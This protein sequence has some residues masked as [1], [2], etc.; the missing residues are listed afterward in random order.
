[1]NPI[2]QNIPV[3]CLHFETTVN[4]VITERYLS[5]IRFCRWSKLG[6]HQKSALFD[7][8]TRA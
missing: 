2:G 1:M 6:H 8:E 3:I 4:T 5:V 7:S